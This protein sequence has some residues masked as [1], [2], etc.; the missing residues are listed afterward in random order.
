MERLAMKKKV[1]I[2]DD[3]PEMLTFSSVVLE[4]SDFLP[5]IAHHGL[6]GLVKAREEKPDLILLDIMMPKKGGVM[7][8]KELKRDP[9]TRGIPVII[10]TGISEHVD[11]K[12]LLDRGSTGKIPPEGHLVKPVTADDLIKEVRKIL[13]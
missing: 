9:D 10:V 1:L 13:G 6:E 3:E 5:I 7:T 8:Y 11:F 4:E 2:V 12:S